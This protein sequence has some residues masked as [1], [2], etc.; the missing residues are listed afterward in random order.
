[1]DANSENRFR[2]HSRQFVVPFPSWPADPTANG[3]EFRKPRSCP[4]VVPI[5]PI[6][7]SGHDFGA[8]SVGSKNLQKERMRDPAVN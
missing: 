2:V 3:R 8:N 7:G 5:V 6:R 4:F 1:M